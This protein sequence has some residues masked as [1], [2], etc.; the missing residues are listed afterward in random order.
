MD[1]D[2]ILNTAIKAA[3]K[4]GDIILHNKAKTIE[5]KSKSDYVTE[6]DVK[7]QDEIK[8]II[9]AEFPD[10]KFLAEEDGGSFT[11]QDKLWIIDPLDGTTNFI[12]DLK[13]S[14]VSIAYF[15]NDE[16][17]VGVIYLPYDDELFYAVKGKGAFLNKAKISISKENDI[18]RSLIATGMPFRIPEKKEA[19]FDCLSDVLGKCSGLRRMGSAA[20]DLAY[21][22]CG[23]FDGFFEGWL[24][25]WDIAAGIL[26]IE[27]AGGKIT[28][29][30]GEKEYFDH[31]CII[32]AN[33]I[34]K[35]NKN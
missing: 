8:S 26:I 23:R 5:I 17:K 10:H 18:S 15:S 14:A 13:H 20:I 22:A 29:F 27:E 9:S 32:A 24:S 11:P 28:D 35:Y 4:A 33:R 6:V 21:I 34:I 31:G 30:K 12:H 16:V 25:P 19:Y 1:Y 7:C 3:K 2:K